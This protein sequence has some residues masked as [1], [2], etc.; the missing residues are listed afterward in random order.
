[1][2]FLYI[3]LQDIL[4][5]DYVLNFKAFHQKTKEIKPFKVSANQIDAHAHARDFMK[6]FIYHVVGY[7]NTW[8]CS[9]F[10]SISSKNKKDIE[11]FVSANQSEAHVHAREFVLIWQCHIIYTCNI[12]LYNKFQSNSLK[13]IKVMALLSISVISRVAR[14]RTCR[15]MRAKWSS[16]RTSTLHTH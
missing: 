12:S 16:F 1:M 10:Q 6:I 5:H 3:I 13:N 8:L 4:I 15:R 9:K 11:I 7:F 2:N 14:A